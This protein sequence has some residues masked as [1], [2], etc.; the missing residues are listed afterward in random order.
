MTGLEIEVVHHGA[1]S[2]LATAWPATDDTVLNDVPD[3][4]CVPFLT[5]RH[6]TGADDGVWHAQ[7]HPAFTPTWADDPAVPE[8]WRQALDR[9][10]TRA[11][12][13]WHL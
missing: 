12:T 4:D 6:P 8:A 13:H 2:W 5:D 11:R 9:L 10:V 7:W 3:P 1:G